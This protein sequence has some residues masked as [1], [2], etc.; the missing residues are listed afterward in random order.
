ME[1]VFVYA[2]YT[3]SCS[4]DVWFLRSFFSVLVMVLY[5]FLFMLFLTTC[6]LRVF[7]LMCG[8]YVFFFLVLVMA[9]C[10]QLF[11]LAILVF[12]FPAS[13]G[14]QLLLFFL[15]LRLFFSLSW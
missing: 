15:V 8:F 6:S 5:C 10:S 12:G 14:V 3:L 2:Y 1:R 9:V 4:F 7:S 13:F 11:S